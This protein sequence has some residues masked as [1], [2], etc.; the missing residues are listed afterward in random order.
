MGVR[1]Q[2]L[3]LRFGVYCVAVKELSLSY[4][5]LVV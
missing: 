1:V 4:Q 2:F 3:G 5:N